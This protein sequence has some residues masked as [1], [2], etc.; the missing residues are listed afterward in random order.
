MSKVTLPS[1][2]SRA[3]VARKRYPHTAKPLPQPVSWRCA[4][5]YTAARRHAVRM[6]T[7]PCSSLPC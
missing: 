3:F 1:S 6:S 2:V 7:A 5:L 4:T